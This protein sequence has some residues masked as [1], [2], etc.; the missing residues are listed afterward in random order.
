MT[1]PERSRSL[2]VRSSGRERLTA[3]RRAGG[4]GIV[5][6][7]AVADPPDAVSEALRGLHFRSR[8]LCR[9]ELSAPWGFTVGQA[10]GA[11]FH[12]VLEGRCFVET[13]HDGTPLA[14]QAGDFVILPRGDVHTVRDSPASPS[15]W[16]E[17]L[18]A[19]SPPDRT[20]RLRH[21][22]GG[23]PTVL[24]CGAFDFDGGA[25]LP[26]LAAL[27][28]R[29]VVRG[30]GPHVGW[31]RLLMDTLALDAE[32]ALPGN[33]PLVDRLMDIVFI[34][35]V[36]AQVGAF[37]GGDAGWLAAMRDPHL[38]AAIAAIHRDPARPWT[39]ARLATLVGMSRTTFATRFALL[40][41]ESPM[42]YLTRFRMARAIEGL[43]EGRMSLAS[44]AE[45][46][47]YASDV[48]FSKA[49]KR[50]VGVGPGAFRR[51]RRA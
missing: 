32:R 6:K 48:A 20:G 41:G 17:D 45:R 10:P 26:L 38:S 5:D 47:G 15:L 11:S 2:L 16:L 28:S 50:H 4:I 18:L 35:A 7:I 3:G 29:M 1:M 9:S 43:R 12:F 39:V 37:T 21:G 14:L 22:G 31:L 30:D 13:K 36:R 25:A 34:Q 40:L 24:L 8:V 46:V 19:K 49:F 44:L 51:G 33:G 42:K 23:A 27:P